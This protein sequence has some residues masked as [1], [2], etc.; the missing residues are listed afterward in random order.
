M[1]KAK[2]LAK[3]IANLVCEIELNIVCT[4]FYIRHVKLAARGPH[5]ALFHF[6]CGP[7][8]P[9]KSAL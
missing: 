9:F 8:L 3:I 4:M 1:K 6:P 7:P 2:Q 5:A